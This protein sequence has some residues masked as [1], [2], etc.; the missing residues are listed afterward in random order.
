[1]V[2]ILDKYPELSFSLLCVRKA[3]VIRCGNLVLHVH[4]YVYVAVLLNRIPWLTYVP[5]VLV[6]SGV[7]SHVYIQF[8]KGDHV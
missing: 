2:L 8:L 4:I 3:I 6:F 7:D 5:I 1:M